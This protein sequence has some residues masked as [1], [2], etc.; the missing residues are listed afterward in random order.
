MGF[1]STSFFVFFS[2]RT[3]EEK[4]TPSECSEVQ[5]LVYMPIKHASFAVD[6]DEK[7]LVKIL[8]NSYLSSAS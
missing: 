8:P 7:P 5:S 4:S 3:S 2:T 1:T 6:M